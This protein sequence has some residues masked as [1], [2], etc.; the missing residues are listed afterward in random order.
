MDKGKD[1]LERAAAIAQQGA[2][3]DEVEHL[4]IEVETGNGGVV[5]GQEAFGH[6]IAEHHE[7]KDDGAQG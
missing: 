5:G 4:L 1:D 2:Q 6:A 3:G 7:A